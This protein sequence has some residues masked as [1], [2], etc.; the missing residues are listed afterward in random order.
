MKKVLI[1][2][3]SLDIQAS[4]KFLLEDEGYACH[5]VVTPEA[6]FD[7]VSTQEV[8]LVLLDMNFTQ[9]TT[10]GKEGLMAIAKLI[11][12]DPLLPIVVMT[13]WATLDLAVAA[14]KQ[15]AADFI[16]KPWDDERLAHSIKVQIE[17]RADRQHLARLSAENERLK[18]PQHTVDFVTQSEKKQRVLTQLTQLA[19]SD[20]N[21]LLTGENGTGKSYY[22]QYVH[23]HSSRAGGSFISINMGAVSDELFNSELFGHK[24]GAFTDAKADRVGAFTLASNGSLFLD[25]IANLSLQSQAKLLQVLEERKYVA[26]GSHKVLDNTARIISATN[27]QLNE[28]IA[29]NQFR[30]DLYYRLNT[31]EVEIPP[32][33]ACPEDILPLAERFLMRFSHDYKKPPPSIMPCAAKA[34]SVYDFPGNVRELKHMM[35]RAVFTCSNAQVFASDLALN[36]T[37]YSALQS[38]NTATASASENH[39]L[40]LDEIIEQAL[41]KRLEFHGGNVS[42]AAKSLGLSR[43]AWYRKMDKYE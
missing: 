39:D 5:G 4:L 42:K 11:Q 17:K 28:A 29:N 27:C 22:A 21:I 9:D 20:M 33:R 13:G 30:Q 26:V 41:F 3:D 8:D 16:A 19:Q 38:M 32:L 2:D 25:E 36:A 6:A 31:V 10:S 18:K 35:E 1:V 37:P 15:G 12:I 14:L 34:L 7:Y 23:E 24:K 43:S 40:T